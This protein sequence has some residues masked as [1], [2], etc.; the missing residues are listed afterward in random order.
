MNL[1]S[2][3][4]T[5]R[6]EETANNE[7]IARGVVDDGVLI[8]E[9]QYYFAPKH[10]DMNRLVVTDRVYICPYRGISYEIDLITSKGVI[11]N[12]AWI[13]PEPKAGYE[14]I[15]GR[16]AFYATGHPAIRMILENE[17]F[18]ER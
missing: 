16:I 15:A 5:I 3:V 7:V 9:G 10:V 4:T 18:S 11:E 8:L 13:Y 2:G 14:P 6:V 12:I 1:K 17:K